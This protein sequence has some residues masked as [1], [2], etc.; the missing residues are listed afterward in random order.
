[1]RLRLGITFLLAILITC[2]TNPE[3]T[4]MTQEFVQFLM[5]YEAKVIPL[6]KEQNRTYFTA[7][8]SGK[9]ED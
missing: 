9:D 2:C 4:E 6:S 1:M 5:A 7:S 8:I 3:K